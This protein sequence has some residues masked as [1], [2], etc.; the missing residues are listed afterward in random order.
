MGAVLPVVHVGCKDPREIRKTAGPMSPGSQTNVDIVCRSKTH[1]T[2]YGGPS[3]LLWGVVFECVV[4]FLALIDSGNQRR[5]IERGAAYLVRLYQIGGGTYMLAVYEVRFEMLAWWM[6]EIQ[7]KTG[8]IL[9]ILKWLQKPFTTLA[10]CMIRETPIIDIFVQLN[11]QHHTEILQTNV[12]ASWLQASMV[13]VSFP[14][15]STVAIVSKGDNECRV[16]E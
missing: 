13:V 8:V 1:E 5:G 12:R 14:A 15:G 6:A 9:G 2:E 11:P 4:A 10:S 3:D 16:P 7:R